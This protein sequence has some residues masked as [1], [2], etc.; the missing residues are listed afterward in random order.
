MNTVFLADVV[1]L[2]HLAYVWFVTL[3]YVAILV[4]WPLGW[5]WIR[6]RAFRRLHLAAI[7]LVAVEAVVGVICPLTWLENL[8]APDRAGATFMG[9][10][11]RNLL[12]YDLPGWIFTVGYVLLLGVALALYWV[13]RPRDCAGEEARPAAEEEVGSLDADAAVGPEDGA[14]AAELR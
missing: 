1:V 13:V 9:R 4:G 14:E 2:L 5:R 10:I 8:L 3:G 11:A 6:N 7:G 12:Y